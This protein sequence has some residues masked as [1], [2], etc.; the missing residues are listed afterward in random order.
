M[1]K[2]T[3]VSVMRQAMPGAE[4]VIK[5]IYQ[6]NWVRKMNSIHVYCKK[7][8]EITEATGRVLEYTVKDGRTFDRIDFF[9]SHCNSRVMIYTPPRLQAQVFQQVRLLN[10]A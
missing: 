8:L 10:A 2:L 3:E 6:M 4:Q 9:C 5:D 1:V 7:C